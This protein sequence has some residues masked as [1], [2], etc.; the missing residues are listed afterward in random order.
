MESAPTVNG[1][2]HD[3][4]GNRN[5]VA[6]QTHVGDDACIVPGTPL[7]RKVPG[8]A[9]AIPYKPWKTT[10]QTGTAATTRAIVGRDALIPPHP[11]AAQTF[12]GGYG[13]RPYETAG[14]AG[15]YG[16]RPCAG[17]RRSGG[18]GEGRRGEKCD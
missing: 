18:A 15:G 5:L 12:A 17:F 1:R 6:P 14:A 7:H 2:V 8:R 3:Q 13:I 16:T 10:R 9:M 11:A 4:P